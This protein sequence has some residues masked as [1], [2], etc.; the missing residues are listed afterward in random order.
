MKRYLLFISTTL[1]LSSCSNISDNN[2]NDLIARAGQNFLYQNQM[3]S[4]SSEQDSMLRYL[5]YIETWA[6]E[7]I[8][9]D[10]SLINLSQSKKNDLDILVEKYKVDLYINSYKDLIVNSII[11]SIVTDEEIESFYN[12]NIENFKLNENLLKYRYLKVPSDNIN[13]SRIRRYIQRLNQSDREFLDSL[14]FQFADL[15]LNDTMWFTEREVISSIEFINQKNKSNYMGINRLYELE[16]DQYIY[17]FII[18]D[19]LKS[20]NIPP[21]SYIYDRIKSNIINQRK[22]NLLQN[23]NKEIL[24]DALKSNKYEVFK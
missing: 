17:Y 8:L 14:N 24:N 20:G 4:F 7:K 9:Y 3:P 2:S 11:D 21:L 15:K 10:L 5:N 16:N 23:I 13:I 12:R 18:K 19:L 1:L 6:K 22:L